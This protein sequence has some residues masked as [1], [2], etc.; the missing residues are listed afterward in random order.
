MNN[1]ELEQQITELMSESNYVEGVEEEKLLQ[2]AW[3]LVPDEHRFD[4]SEWSSIATVITESFIGYYHKTNQIE[5]MKK[6]LAIERQT[7]SFGNVRNDLFLGQM[8]FE[9]GDFEQ[10]LHYFKVVYERQ[11]YA[12]FRYYDKKYW[13]FFLNRRLVKNNLNLTI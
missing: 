8:H 2:Q 1:Q 10:A 5:N 9:L 12:P 7:N 11:G 4:G 6:W 13:H 3:D